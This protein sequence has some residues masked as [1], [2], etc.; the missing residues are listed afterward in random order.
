MSE[1]IE[2]KRKVLEITQKLVAGGLLS[3]TGG[4]VSLRIDGEDALAVT[5]SSKDY[6][7]MSPDD[8]VVC[9]F[10]RKIL[11][12]KFNPSVETGMHIAVYQARPDVNAVVHTHQVG[13]S[14]FTLIGAPIPALFDEQTLNLGPE[15]AFVPYGLSGSTDLL[16]NIAAAVENKC[17][18]Y[19]LQNHGALVLAADLD[20]AMR[21]ALILEKTAQ[22][23]LAALTTGKEIT[24]LPKQSIDMLR[25]LLDG[26]QKTEIT[27]KKKLAE[28]KSE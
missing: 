14:V 10:N 4:N 20:Q 21:N 19:I 18:A 3:A 25:M 23:Y 28:A 2:Y 15:A 27:R 26:K 16:K 12:G 24:T 9:D 8:I 17:N 6:T 11:D 5:P 13:A 7:E 22:V 1:Y